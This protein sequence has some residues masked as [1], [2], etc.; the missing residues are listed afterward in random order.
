MLRASL[1]KIAQLLG[2]VAVVG[3]LGACEQAPGTPGPRGPQGERG[4]QGDPGEPGTSGTP[5]WAD[6]LQATHLSDTVYAIG[7]SYR[8]GTN[9]VIG[10]GF[11]A[12]Y[13]N[14]IWTNAHVALALRDELFA[15]SHL[16]PR[17]F[18]IKS[19]TVI[20]GADSYVPFGFNVHPGYD[21][22]SGSPDVAIL[23]IRGEITRFVQFLPK[24]F[25]TQLRVGQP[26]ATVGF[27]GEIGD[28]SQTAPIS[29]FK[30]GTI[31]G[32]R[33]YS[34]AGAQV[35]PGNSTVVQHNLNL[36]AATSGSPI[37]DHNGWVVA[38]NNAGTENLMFDPNTG[39]PTRLG[40][41]DHGFGIRVDEI[42]SFIDALESGSS[43][44]GHPDAGVEDSSAP[45]RL[46]VY[47]AFPDTGNNQR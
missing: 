42:W 26:V 14:V 1:E 29:A 46:T 5:N 22:T 47:R 2:V 35:T 16:R 34:I 33:P 4:Q 28:L 32:L 17:P 20:G 15:L 10:T 31:G 37:I 9:Y 7:I 36:S 8:D 44:A 12:H 41:G 6:V 19:G 40:S 18:A 39:R 13:A 24:R 11:S 45:G 25:A 23:T 21:G 43:S 38:I 30:N 27:P 3:L